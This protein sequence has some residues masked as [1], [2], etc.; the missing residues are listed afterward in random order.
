MAF[1][2]GHGVPVDAGK[3][4]MLLHFLSVVLSAKSLLRIPIQQEKDDLAGV[5][6]HRVRD[7]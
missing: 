5:V 1:A 3:E 2:S 6:G 7:F 4:F